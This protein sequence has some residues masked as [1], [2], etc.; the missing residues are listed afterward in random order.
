MSD[1]K[2]VKHS[3]FAGALS[4]LNETLPTQAWYK[5]NAKGAFLIID[6]AEAHQSFPDLGERPFP[7]EG[8][9]PQDFS[10]RFKAWADKKYDVE[11]TIGQHDAVKACVKYYLEQGTYPVGPYLVNLIREFELNKE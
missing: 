1:K 9:R 4:L 7:A 8:E 6:A 5:G 2:T 10:P 3:F 11:L